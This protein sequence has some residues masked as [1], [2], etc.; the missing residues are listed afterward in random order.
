MSEYDIAA[1]EPTGPSDFAPLP[2]REAQILT[3]LQ[4]KVFVLLAIGVGLQILVLVA[5]IA[6]RSRPLVS[7][8]NVLLRVIPVDPRDLFRGDYVIL[9]YDFS[10]VPPSGVDGRLDYQKGSQESAGQTVYALL[11]PE[12][13][14]KHWRCECFTAFRPASGVFLRGTLRSWGRAE[15]G[16]ESYYVQEGTGRKYEQAIRS[17]NLSAEVAIG[18]DGQATLRSLQIE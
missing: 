4:S 15:F 16:I 6:Q 5:M 8:T 18:R 1:G 10:R 13:D 11:V 12:A 17:R 3:W 7:G 2:Q 9:S 14:G